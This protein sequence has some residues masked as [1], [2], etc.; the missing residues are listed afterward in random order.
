[1]NRRIATGIDIGTY[2]TKVVVVEYVDTEEG[3]SIQII[4][5]GLSE[6]AGSHDTDM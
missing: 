4:G 5:T 6:T 2:Q 3:P 1:M